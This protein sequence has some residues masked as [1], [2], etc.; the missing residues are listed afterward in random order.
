MRKPH[1]RAKLTD[2]QVQRMRA[3]YASNAGKTG[4]DARIGY[5]TL[6]EMFGCGESTAR[7]ICKH[8]TRAAA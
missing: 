2:E 4:K 7:D 6:A 3:I 5:K 1:H 8:W